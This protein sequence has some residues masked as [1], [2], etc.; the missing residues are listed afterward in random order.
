MLLKAACSKRLGLS[1][2]KIKRAVNA[3]YNTFLRIT[4]RFLSPAASFIRLLSP[5]ALPKQPLDEF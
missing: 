2:L 5:S 4:L 1:Y 3:G